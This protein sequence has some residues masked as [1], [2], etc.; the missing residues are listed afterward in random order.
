MCNTLVSFSRDGNISVT[1]CMPRSSVLKSIKINGGIECRRSMKNLWLLTSIWSITAGSNVP[2]TLGRYA[3]DCVDVDATYKRRS[4]MHQW[5]SHL[6]QMMMQICSKMQHSFAAN[7]FP[8]GATTTWL[9]LTYMTYIEIGCVVTSLVGW[10]VV[11]WL[12]RAC[13]VAKRCILGL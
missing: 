11:G 5:I 12:S 3:S 8:P 7:E 9:T 4:A 6:S 2:S 10:L 13:T 1:D